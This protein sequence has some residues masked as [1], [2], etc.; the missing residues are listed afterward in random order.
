[1]YLSFFTP[2]TPVSVTLPRCM[3]PL[4]SHL[5]HPHQVLHPRC[6]AVCTLQIYTS[7]TGGGRWPAVLAAVCTFHFQSSYTL[8]LGGLV[9]KAVC[10]FHFYTSNTPC[11]W[12][13]RPLATVCTFHFYASYTWPTASVSTIKAACIFHPH[14]GGVIIVLVKKEERYFPSDIPSS[15]WGRTAAPVICWFLKVFISKL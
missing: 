14:G 10:T 12:G 9:K 7:Y 5:L 8:A 13:W 2:L 11:G 4:N 3:Y 6:T 15:D 1:M